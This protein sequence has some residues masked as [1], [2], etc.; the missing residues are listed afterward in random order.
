MEIT[1]QML[2]DAYKI[3]PSKLSHVLAESIHSLSM[4]PLDGDEVQRNIQGILN[5]QTPTT[6]VEILLNDWFTNGML[7][8]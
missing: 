1:G 8:R 3:N 6:P 7:K 4:I 5:G 2:K